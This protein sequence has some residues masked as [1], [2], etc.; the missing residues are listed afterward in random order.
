A[1]L[2]GRAMHRGT[3]VTGVLAAGSHPAAACTANWRRRPAD[4]QTQRSVAVTFLRPLGQR[5]R[6]NRSEHRPSVGLH[7]GH[8]DLRS[9]RSVEHDPVE[10]WAA[11]RHLDEFAG[12]CWL[13]RHSVLTDCSRRRSSGWL[14]ARRSSYTSSSPRPSAAEQHDRLADRLR[15]FTGEWVAIKDDD[16]LHASDSPQALVGWLARHGQKA[17]SVFR[18]PEDDLAASG[19][20]PL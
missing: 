20:A 11:A 12:A 2:A 7:D 6:M 16:V 4:E 15:E 13:H 1:L 3:R 8:H 18:V 19:L 14:S 5:V 10:L 17:D 9:A